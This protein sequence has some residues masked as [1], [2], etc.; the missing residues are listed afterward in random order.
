MTDS[1]NQAPATS[2]K[3]QSS[4]PLLA[5]SAALLRVRVLPAEFARL[6]GV[7]KQSVSRWI[8]DGKITINALDG[9]LDV[10]AATEQLLR[11]SDAGRMRS[12]VLKAA[13]A[14]VS[15]LRQSAAEADDRIAEVQADLDAL[16]AR[17]ADLDERYAIDVD[18]AERFMD[19][20]RNGEHLLRATSNIREWQEVVD[21]MDFEA[22]AHALALV[23]AADELPDLDQL[24]L[25]AAAVLA[26]WPDDEADDEADAAAAAALCTTD[27]AGIFN[28]PIDLGAP[29]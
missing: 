4:L 21:Q 12:R 2:E 10:Q 29:A 22:S 7:S 8:A 27:P 24:E 16:R 18:A 3:A 26:A 15:Q 14:S 13:V 9:R 5:D 1:Q 19:L 23:E 20:V 11:T 17:Y 25:E 6:I 28:C